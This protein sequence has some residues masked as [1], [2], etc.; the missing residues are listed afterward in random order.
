MAHDSVPNLGRFGR[1]Y[2]RE[3]LERQLAKGATTEETFFHAWSPYWRNRRNHQQ[4]VKRV[5]K[6][7]ETEDVVGI[8]AFIITTLEGYPKIPIQIKSSDEKAFRHKRISEKRDRIPVVAVY[9]SDSHKMI[10]DRTIKAILEF[11]PQLSAVWRS[12]GCS[13]SPYTLTALGL[14]N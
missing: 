11:Y 8:D 4:W 5:I 14:S 2:A 12:V 13:V 10:R 9:Y 1:Q 6:A 7:S 3:K